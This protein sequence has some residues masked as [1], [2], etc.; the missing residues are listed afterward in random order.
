MTRD[1]AD[2]LSVVAHEGGHHGGFHG[3]H[4]MLEPLTVGCLHV[5]EG[6][7][8]PLVLVEFSFPVGKPL[9]WIGP[10]PDGLIRHPAVAGGSVCALIA[11]GLGVPQMR[12][13]ADGP[14]RLRHLPTVTVGAHRPRLEPRYR[15]TS[16]VFQSS[17]VSFKIPLIW[18]KARVTVNGAVI[19][20]RM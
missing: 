5:Y 11:D 20:L 7:G 10:F 12:T 16:V 1:H 4:V 2:V 8:H 15:A 18:Q 19:P 13:R 6:E 9:V 17:T 14:H 3:H